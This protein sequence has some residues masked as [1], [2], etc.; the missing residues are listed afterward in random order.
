MA[1][2]TCG[3][4]YFFN[5]KNI[6]HAKPEPPE[7]S[8]KHRLGWV[9]GTDPACGHFEPKRRADDGEHGVAG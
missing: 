9:F 8:V 7:C 1:E 4:C 2:H 5:W 6:L 3:Q